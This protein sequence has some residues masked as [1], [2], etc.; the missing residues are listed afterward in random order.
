MLECWEEQVFLQACTA[1]LFLEEA[2]WLLT[3]LISSADNALPQAPSQFLGCITPINLTRKTTE[4]R[5]Y[6]N[7]NSIQFNLFTC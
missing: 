7:N 2:D 6:N 4:F 5:C 1:L 3:E